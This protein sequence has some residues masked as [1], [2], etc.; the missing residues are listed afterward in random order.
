VGNSI[1]YLLNGLPPHCEIGTPFI[2]AI[3]DSDRLSLYVTGQPPT[4]ALFHSLRGVALARRVSE[5]EVGTNLAIAQK[6][7]T[8]SAALRA[9]IRTAAW[10]PVVRQFAALP[11]LR[12][13]L[14]TRCSAT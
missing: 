13:G 14:V 3:R 9:F 10:L 11:H 4:R 1:R 12:V 7:I 5:G 6:R 2:V 8:D